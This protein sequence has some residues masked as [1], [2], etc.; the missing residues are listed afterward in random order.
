[1][2]RTV[3]ESEHKALRAQV[4]LVVG[5]GLVHPETMHLLLLG[6]LQCFPLRESNS[7]D[8]V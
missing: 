1:M 7:E 8:C 3:F 6:A 4:L 5:V 2:E